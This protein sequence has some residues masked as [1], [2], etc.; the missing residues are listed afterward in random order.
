MSARKPRPAAPAQ[1]PGPYTVTDFRSI[2]ERSGYVMHGD[3]HII[4]VGTCEAAR[5]LADLMNE[6]AALAADAHLFD[7][8]EHWARRQ[9]GHAITKALGLSL[10]LSDAFNVRTPES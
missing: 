4:T 2:G 3:T 1:V 6:A 7:H 8:D 10:D 5:R 9:V